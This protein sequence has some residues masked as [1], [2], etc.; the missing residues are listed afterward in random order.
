[1]TQMN[2]FY[3]DV[4]QDLRKLKPTSIEEGQVVHTCS[5]SP[6]VAFLGDVGVALFSLSGVCGVLVN[7]EV[8]VSGSGG[9]HHHGLGVLC[10][11]LRP[12]RPRRTDHR[13]L[14]PVRPATTLGGMVCLCVCVID[15]ILTLCWFLSVQDP[16]RC[17]NLPPAA[18]LG[19]EVPPGRNQTNNPASV[20]V[21]GESGAHVRQVNCSIE[22]PSFILL[23]PS[24]FLCSSSVSPL[25]GTAQPHFTCTTCCKVRLYLLRGTCHTVGKAFPSHFKSFLPFLKSKHRHGRRPWC[26]D[27]RQSPPPSS[28]TWPSGTSRWASAHSFRSTLSKA[29]SIINNFFF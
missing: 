29:G 2:L 21:R 25:S 20:R 22:P 19:E 6:P 5:L 3:H 9:V 24:F 18:F 23:A 8:V 11:P 12:G 1:M 14:G 15:W 4:T 7:N 17:R 13:P 26:L 10:S 16:C 28:S 27:L